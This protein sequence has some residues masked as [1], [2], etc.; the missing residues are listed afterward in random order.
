MIIVG[1]W[2]LLVLLLTALYWWRVSLIEK[3]YLRLM[4]R[5]EAEF[6]QALKENDYKRTRIILDRI[7]RVR[8]IWR[9]V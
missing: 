6:E 4:A 2:F 3:R 5:L 9:R 7:M 8:Y 1:D